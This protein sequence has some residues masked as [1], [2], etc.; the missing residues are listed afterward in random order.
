MEMPPLPRFLRLTLKRLRLQL[1]YDVEVGSAAGN[2]AE[3]AALLLQDIVRGC[4]HASGLGGWN[5]GQAVVV[6]DENV[7]RIDPDAA[8]HDRLL[9]REAL[10]EAKDVLGMD[11]PVVDL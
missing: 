5:R 2:L 8:G 4:E 6:A 11:E 3:N 7:A 1:P 10:H 9:E